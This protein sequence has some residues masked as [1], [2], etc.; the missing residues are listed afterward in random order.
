MNLKLK[1]NTS[2]SVKNRLKRK[3]RIRKKVAGTAERPRLSVFRSGKHIY[4]QLID[5]VSGKTLVASSSLKLSSQAGK[6]LAKAVGADLAKQ[7]TEKSLS[8]VVFDR[9][10]F[11]YHGRVKALADSAR[12][13][14]LKF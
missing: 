10:G 12:E 13:A 4:A 3:I 11:I 1:K 2:A 5:D 14:G 8:Q 7:A 6:D 9:G